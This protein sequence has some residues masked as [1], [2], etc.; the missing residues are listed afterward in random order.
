MLK[1]LAIGLFVL[2]LFLMI[3]GLEQ[4][5]AGII[6]YKG[7]LS[8]WTIQNRS[9]G[10]WQSSSGIRY[11]PEIGIKQ[12]L[13]EGSFIDIEVSANAV[14]FSNSE[15]S[16]SQVDL[17]LYRAKIRLATPK[18]ETRLGLQQIN[19]GPARLLRP[20]KWFDRL[21]PN[22]PLQ[23]T[24]GVYGLRFRYYAENNAN[25]WLWILTGSDQLKGYEVL[26]TVEEKPE[27][28]GRVQVP[29]GGGE[30]AATLHSRE[31][32]GGKYFLPQYSES[33]YALDGQWDIGIGIWFEFVIQHS[34]LDILLEKWTKTAS[35]GI[36]YT[37]GVGS[38]VYFVLEHMAIAPSSNIFSWEEPVG[39]S[40]FLVSYP[41]SL[42]D[43]LSL[44]G[45]YAWDEE[46]HHVTFAWQR[47]YD[48]FGINLALFH[49]PDR[50][51]A[52]S[53]Q[54]AGMAGYGARLMIVFDH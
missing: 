22:D 10:G 39:I 19:F 47:N 12:D 15:E 23:L 28:G 20:L 42:L 54:S 50:D 13:K 53:T 29:L 33:R 7:Q 51:D 32:D 17:K 14:A 3:L 46:Y 31:V 36:D 37:I 48:R 21:D 49:S 52:G 41:L 16:E 40:A 9:Q 43:S 38:G 30:I 11:I 27:Y 6:S 26:P 25:L 44:I 45:F 2:A 4:T 18:T 34:D 1:R 24:E 8:A 5:H 35:L